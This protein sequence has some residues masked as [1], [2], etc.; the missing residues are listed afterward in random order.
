LLLAAG[1]ITI[2]ITIA[3]RLRR[4]R[5]RRCRSAAGEVERGKGTSARFFVTRDGPA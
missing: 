5:R 3:P 2:W 4:S 1:E